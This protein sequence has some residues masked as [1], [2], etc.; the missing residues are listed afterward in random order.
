MKDLIEDELKSKL[1]PVYSQL[2]KEKFNQ[3]VCTF[4]VQWGKKYPTRADTGILF[5]G[6]AV[7]GWITKDIDVNKLFDDE[8]ENRILIGKIKLNG[9]II[10][11][12]TKMSI[13][14]ID[15]HSGE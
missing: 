9:C 14:P 15:Q 13:I 5:V 11:L 7:N 10:L 2:L 3:D 12:E 1:K 6:K 8:F 4:A